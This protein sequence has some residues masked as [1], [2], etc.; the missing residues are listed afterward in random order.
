MTQANSDRIKAETR[1]QAAASLAAPSKA[2]PEAAYKLAK[3]PEHLI[4]DYNPQNI[5]GYWPF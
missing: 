5:A 3:F 1:K 2:N 4:A